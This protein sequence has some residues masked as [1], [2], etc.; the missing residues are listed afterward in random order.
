VTF[1]VE[2]RYNL[3]SSGSCRY[4]SQESIDGYNST[5]KNIEMLKICRWKD[6]SAGTPP[7]FFAVCDKSSSL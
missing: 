4:V 2:R 5:Q 7:C 6:C 1:V 3:D